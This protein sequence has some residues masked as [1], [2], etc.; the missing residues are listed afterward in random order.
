MGMVIFLVTDPA[1]GTGLWSA[2]CR[3]GI[4]ALGGRDDTRAG[5]RDNVSSLLSV[6]VSYLT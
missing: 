5:G 6:S 3:V 2:E 1:I 4:R